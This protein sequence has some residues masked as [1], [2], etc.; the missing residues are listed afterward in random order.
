MKTRIRAHPTRVAAPID[1]VAPF[2]RDGGMIARA[3]FVLALLMCAVPALAFDGSRKGFVLGAGLGGSMVDSPTRTDSTRF[4]T[5]SDRKTKP[6]IATDFTLGWGISDRV[7]VAYSNSVAWFQSGSVL[8]EGITAVAVSYFI[9]PRAP[10]RV[11][12]VGV[13]LAARN[14]PFQGAVGETGLGVWLGAGY[15]YKPHWLVRGRLAIRSPE[16]GWKS[17]TLTVTLNRL[18]Y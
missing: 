1:H 16:S 6:G 7:V 15:E 10:S 17:L 9:S 14:A 8:T 4:E 2:A 13:G 11:L 12:E 5:V 3:W 18:G